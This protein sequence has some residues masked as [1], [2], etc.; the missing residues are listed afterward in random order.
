MFK[1]NFTPD[2]RPDTQKLRVLIAN[3]EFFLLCGY[4]L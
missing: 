3:D 1:V 4:Q 2:I